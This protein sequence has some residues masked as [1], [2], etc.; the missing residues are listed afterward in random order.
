[1]GRGVQEANDDSAELATLEQAITCYVNEHP[2][3]AD[4]VEGV[5]NWWLAESGINASRQKVL[6]A[7]ENLVQTGFLSK[8]KLRDN[9]VIYTLSARKH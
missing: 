7:L 8:Q 5:A 9:S 2:S 3:A 4:A 6:Q 1:M